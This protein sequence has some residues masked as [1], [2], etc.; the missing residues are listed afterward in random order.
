M[1]RLMLAVAL[2]TLFGSQG[3]A[4][5]DS[6]KFTLTVAPTLTITAPADVPKTHDTT[7]ANQTFDPQNWAVTCNNGAGAT[8]A[9]SITTFSNGS[10]VRDSSLTV[11]VASS[12]QAT[13][14]WQVTTVGAQ[15]TD[16]VNSVNT[17]TVNADSD[18]PGNATFTV[19]VTFID[20]DYSVLPAGD[21]V[22]TVTGTLTAK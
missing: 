9:F 1:K 4:A 3:F 12:D 14:N 19:N 21:Y 10:A 5:N 15:S 16:N 18:G 20:S 22:A 11:S 7:D 8:V 6:Q 13:A 17:A 2:L